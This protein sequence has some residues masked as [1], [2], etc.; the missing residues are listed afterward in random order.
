MLRVFEVVHIEL[1]QY[2]AGQL[3]IA[4]FFSSIE[5]INY[6]GTDASIL[7]VTAVTAAYAT[8]AVDQLLGK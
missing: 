8:A 7:V 4:A 5:T 1:H 2:N 3:L 6:K